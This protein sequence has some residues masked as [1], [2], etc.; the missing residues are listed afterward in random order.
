MCKF[1]DA[2]GGEVGGWPVLV[3]EIRSNYGSLLIGSKS[4]GGMVSWID[5]RWSPLVQATGNV[6]SFVKLRAS[7]SD[8]FRR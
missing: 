2:L 5:D 7:N 4:L 3:K 1:V 6:T 8:K